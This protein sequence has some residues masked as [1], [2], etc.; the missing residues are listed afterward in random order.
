MA[1]AV[2]EPFNAN[3]FWTALMS[4]T[5]FDSDL[6]G[7]LRKHAGNPR[8]SLVAINVANDLAS[9]VEKLPGA[10]G[11]AMRTSAQS[12][13]LLICMA[14]PGC[15]EGRPGRVLFAQENGQLKRTLGSLVL[16]FRD[17]NGE[18]ALSFL[19][20]N[21]DRITDKGRRA[22]WV[23]R[24]LMKA[25]RRPALQLGNGDAHYT[26]AETDLARRVIRS[27]AQN[28]NALSHVTESLID[29]LPHET[30]R[31]IFQDMGEYIE[32]LAEPHPASQ[33]LAS[34]LADA[35]REPKLVRGW[36]KSRETKAVREAVHDVMMRLAETDAMRLEL[37]RAYISLL[38]AEQGEY[39]QDMVDEGCVKLGS[40][41]YSGRTMIHA[42]FSALADGGLNGQSKEM[43]KKILQANPYD[44]EH[45]A[46]ELAQSWKWDSSKREA[47]REIRILVS[48]AK[49][50]AGNRTAWQAFTQNLQHLLPA[51]KADRVDV[52]QPHALRGG[53]G[54]KQA[55]SG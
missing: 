9:K 37:S 35:F 39:A 5:I 15:L 48:V 43:L 4:K 16:M 20:F 32:Q 7:M 41:A 14:Y 13:L 45:V 1:D 30:S 42:L 36:H 21:M 53:A 12:R 40:Q 24:E 3:A 33:S 11:S 26:D 17:A 49:P 54:N 38:G 27:I 28:K 44:V 50:D 52:Q 18:A 23:Y 6:Q 34:R 19:L 46:N 10:E 8:A 55:R 29:W 31:S 25:L 47:V 2:Q 51:R 22:D